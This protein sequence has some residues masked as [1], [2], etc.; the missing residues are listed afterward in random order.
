MIFFNLLCIL[1]KLQEK[2]RPGEE[3]VKVP[4]G[5]WHSLFIILRGVTG[6]KI[7]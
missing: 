1:S 3:S 6:V 5:G 7:F 2:I 4:A